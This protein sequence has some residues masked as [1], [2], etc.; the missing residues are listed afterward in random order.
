VAEVPR[1]VVRLFERPQH[2]RGERD[3]A[4]PVATPP[5]TRNRTSA[6]DARRFSRRSRGAPNDRSESQPRGGVRVAD[7][8]ETRPGAFEQ[9]ELFTLPFGF[10]TVAPPFVTIR[11][12]TD[13]E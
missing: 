1:R 9:L 5:L 11:S 7:A 2:Q 12:P 4:V 13:P 6:D 10:A 3:P 8:F